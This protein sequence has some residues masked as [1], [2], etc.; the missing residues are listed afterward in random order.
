MPAQVPAPLGHLFAIVLTFTLTLNLDLTTNRPDRTRFSFPRKFNR[1]K[2]VKPP[3]RIAHC[4]G[5]RTVSIRSPLD[6]GGLFAV[7]SPAICGQT[8]SDLDNHRAIRRQT[9]RVRTGLLLLLRQ[10]VGPRSLIFRIS[11]L[12]GIT[13]I[14]IQSSRFPH[15]LIL[16]SIARFSTSFGNRPISVLTRR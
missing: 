14:S 16:L 8:V 1:G 5:V 2:K 15:P 12:G 4:N 7:T 9:R 6:R 13:V 10:P 3:P 11:R